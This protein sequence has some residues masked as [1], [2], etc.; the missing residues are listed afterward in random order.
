MKV[1]NIT[2]G[3][4]ALGMALGQEE[5]P[6]GLGIIRGDDVPKDAFGTRG[7]CREFQSDHPDLYL[8]GHD[9]LP[10]KFYQEICENNKGWMDGG[11]HRHVCHEVSPGFTFIIWIWNR[12]SRPI[13]ID[14]QVC[15]DRF[16]SII[17]HCKIGGVYEPDT[18]YLYYQFDAF[19]NPC[20]T[21]L[22][23]PEGQP[24]MTPDDP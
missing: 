23:T 2:L 1:S 6:P 22:K 9:G 14:Q 18:D 5:A 15:E 12:F 4:M 10:V 3:S 17:D 21:F 16:Q 8:T 11:S 13:W 19:P 20:P 24:H 7:T